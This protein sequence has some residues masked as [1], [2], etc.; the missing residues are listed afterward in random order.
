M[1]SIIIRSFLHTATDETFFHVCKTLPN[2]KLT[3]E[4]TKKTIGAVMR[5]F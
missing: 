4:V 3:S 2:M 5:V 1:N